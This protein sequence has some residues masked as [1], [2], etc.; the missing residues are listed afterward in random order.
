MPDFELEDACAAAPVCGIDE[1]GRGPWAGPVVAAAVILHRDRLD[2]DLAAQIDDSKRV[3]RPLRGHLYE[4]IGTV[5]E[6]GVGRATV[7]EIDAVGILKATFLAMERAV[8]ALPV[9]PAH[10]LVDGR[11]TL[12]LCCPVRPVI[13]GD[14]LSLSIAAAS[15]VA[16]VTRDR[17][18]RA[19]HDEFPGYGW[20]TNV[21]Y[22][23]PAH[24][25]ALTRLGITPH[26][27][28]SYRPIFE[29]ILRDSA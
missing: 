14:Q 10:V 25:A 7:D 12:P 18:M 16:K 2:R 27:R 23:T 28:R 22:G 1:V 29:L 26:H 19:L 15:I 6:V 11:D 21:G 4:R 8:A 5:A 9:A 24:R 20:D 13:R 17:E 3:P